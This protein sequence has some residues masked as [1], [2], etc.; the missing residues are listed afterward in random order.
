MK[1]GPISAHEFSALIEMI[2]EDAPE[3]VVDLLDTF[4]DESVTLVTTVVDAHAAGDQA[5]MLRPVHSLKSSSAS[6]GAIRLS[7]LCADLESYLRGGAT[8]LDVGAQV[9]AI[10]AEFTLVQAA[11][12]VEK[13]QLL[14]T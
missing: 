8:S 1:D 5:S 10:Q 9:T 7:Q 3:V 12:E 6:V 4:L 2:G 13:E 11:L 14:N